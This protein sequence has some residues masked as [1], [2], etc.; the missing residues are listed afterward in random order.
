MVCSSGLKK[1]CDFFL[2]FWY[3]CLINWYTWWYMIIGL[4]VESFPRN[5]CICLSFLFRRIF[6]ILKILIP[7][8]FSPEVRGFII[9]HVFSGCALLQ[10]WPFIIDV[11][12]RRH[13]PKHSTQILR[14]LSHTVSVIVSG[15]IK[16]LITFFTRTWSSHIF[17]FLLYIVLVQALRRNI[18]ADQCGVYI[19][20]QTG[21]LIMVAASL[22]ART[23]CDVWMIHNGTVI[24]R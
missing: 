15:R 7:R 8:W 12:T 10:W 13:N 22:I 3:F 5:E 20:F 9:L 11:D 18:K 24:E 19:N 1:N 4:A 21:Y 2:S 16:L 6:H 14:T 23:L 17:S